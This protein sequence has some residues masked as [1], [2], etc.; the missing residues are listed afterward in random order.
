[1]VLTASALKSRMVNI[2]GIMVGAYDFLF[3]PK[4]ASQFSRNF[5]SSPGLLLLPLPATFQPFPF[6]KPV[7]LKKQILI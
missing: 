2:D 6:I 1:M 5:L 4:T 3:L 7:L